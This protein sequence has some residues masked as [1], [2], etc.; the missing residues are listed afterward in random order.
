MSNP[1]IESI[2]VT[3][4]YKDGSKRQFVVPDKVTRLERSSK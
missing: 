3:I 1:E 2:K 4:K